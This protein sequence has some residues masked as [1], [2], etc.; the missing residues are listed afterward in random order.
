[1]LKHNPKLRKLWNKAPKRKVGE[2]I[3]TLDMRYKASKEFL[4]GLEEFLEAGVK[5]NV[6]WKIDNLIDNLIDKKL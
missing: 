4:E 2:G 6:H 5:K 3:E 1:M